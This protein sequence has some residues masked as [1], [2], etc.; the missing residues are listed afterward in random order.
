MGAYVL[1]Y[2]SFKRFLYKHKFYM[3]NVQGSKMYINASDV[4]TSLHLIML[5]V[6][7]KCQTELFK[8]MVK[9]GDVVV[10]LGASIGYF[11]LL[12]ARLVG[13]E[14]K[15]YAFE[16]E[17][18]NFLLL[19]KNIALN[20]YDNI[21][22]IRKAVSDREGFAK[23]FLSDDYGSH[24]LYK[25]DNAKTPIITETVT[26]DNFFRK[27]GYHVDIIKIDVEGA[28]MVAFLGMEKLIRENKK[29]KIFVEFSPY[30]IREAGYSPEEFLSKITEY[31]FKIYLIDELSGHVRCV[32][33]RA[34]LNY[35][36]KHKLADL[37]LI[38]QENT[39]T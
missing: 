19:C 28:E 12:A 22:A 11:T 25:F 34:L 37:L 15:V 9:K 24:S 20:G 14:G 6:W 23:L 35:A 2:K 10:D 1:L 13:K 17:P 21:V 5:G 7:G 33:T 32:S 8:K 18:R 26:L 29:L 39:L 38:K 36:I 30:R 3:T 4:L 27:E 31:G 16:P